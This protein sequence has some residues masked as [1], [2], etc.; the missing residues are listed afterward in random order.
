MIEHV[1]KENCPE[2]YGIFIS[3]TS[4]SILFHWITEGLVQSNYFLSRYDSYD[5]ETKR[6]TDT[7]ILVS[8]NSSRSDETSIPH[9]Q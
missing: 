1:R 4:E 9:Y 8:S 2:T 6:E 5:Y 7:S 3:I